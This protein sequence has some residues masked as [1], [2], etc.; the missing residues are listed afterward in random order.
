MLNYY[1]IVRGK[2]IYADCIFAS[3]SEA[4]D[5]IEKFIPDVRDDLE[6]KELYVAT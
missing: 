5:E 2:E 3:R 6:V 1:A 4:E